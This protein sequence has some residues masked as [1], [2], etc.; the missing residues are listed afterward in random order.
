MRGL[1]LQA[2]M[3]EV[4]AAVAVFFW[5]FAEVQSAFNRGPSWQQPWNA[6]PLSGR[7]EVHLLVLTLQSL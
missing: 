5:A 7:Q 1:E 4:K 3:K 2:K 6:P